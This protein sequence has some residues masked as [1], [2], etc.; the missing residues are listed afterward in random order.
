MKKSKMLILNIVL[1]LLLFAGRAEAEQTCIKELKQ[2]STDGFLIGVG[3]AGSYE[4]AKGRALS[5]AISFL[6]IKVSAKN[7]IVDLGSSSIQ[8]QQEIETESEMLV[9]GSKVIST[10]DEGTAK[11][12]TIGI[13]KALIAKL[14]VTNTEQRQNQVDSMLKTLKENPTPA[15]QSAA[16]VAYNRM[17]SVEKEDLERWLVI[18]RTREEFRAV[19][20]EMRSEIEGLLNRA[21]KPKI[22]KLMVIAQGEVARKTLPALLS[23]LSSEGI[24]AVEGGSS[25]AAIWQCSLVKGSPLGNA[26]RFTA[27]CSLSNTSYS[28]EPIVVNGMAPVDQT[29]MEDTAARL[30]NGRISLAH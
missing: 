26:V 12:I 30:V 9:R 2:S 11:K 7:A 21:G 1:A 3:E 4:E 6:G 8:V 22:D 15:N 25:E 16:K 5:D 27:Q 14:I 19:S 17:V 29:V 23:K 20:V 24:S 13:P 10:C 28:L 18:G